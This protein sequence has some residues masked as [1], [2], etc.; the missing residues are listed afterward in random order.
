MMVLTINHAFLT[1]D[2]EVARAVQIASSFV[3]MCQKSASYLPSNNMCAGYTI[4]I[5]RSGDFVL[6]GAS[7]PGVLKFSKILFASLKK[8]E[9]KSQM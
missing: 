9:K 4:L 2:H 7:D 1:T 8:C 5:S 6:L 3:F